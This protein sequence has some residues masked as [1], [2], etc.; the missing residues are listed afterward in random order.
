MRD[1][2]H[3]I[4]PATGFQEEIFQKMAHD[5][6]LDQLQ[7]WQKFVAVSFDEMKIKESLVYDKHSDNLLGFVALDDISNHL[8]DIERQCKLGESTVIPTLASHILMVFVRGV[9]IHLNFPLAQFPSHGI[10]AGQLYPVI[11]EAIMQ[12]ELHGFKVI[13]ITSDGA[14]PNRKLYRMM[15]VSHTNQQQHGNQLAFPYCM[16][17]VYTS[18]DRKISFISDV[19]HLLK[20]TRN[21]W[22]N[23]FGHSFKCKLWVSICITEIQYSCVSVPG[24]YAVVPGTY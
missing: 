6:D 7:E 21:C 3:H 17:N 11:T 1:Y 16:P 19:P 18:E 9:F 24:T 5:V 23:S 8:S 13:S 10:A 15:H 22:A 2:T 20:T 12:L 4:P 14:A